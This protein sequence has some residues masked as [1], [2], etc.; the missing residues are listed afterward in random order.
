M[1]SKEKLT[2]VGWRILEDMYSVAEPPLD[3]KKFREDVF[4]KKIKCPKDWQRKHTITKKQYD[5]IVARYMKKDT[6]IDSEWRSLAWMMLD[7]SPM[8]REEVE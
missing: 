6:V 2:E 1:R 5:E 8:F 4:A 3:F 7:Y